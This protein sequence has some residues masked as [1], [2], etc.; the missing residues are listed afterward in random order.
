MRETRVTPERLSHFATGVAVAAGADPSEA[1]LLAQVMVWSDLRGHATQGVYLLPILVKRLGLGLVRSPADMNLE[2]T[3]P[4]AARLDARH[5]FGQ[6]AGRRAMDEAIELARA[7]GIGI[8]TV[9]NSNHYGAAGYYAARAAESGLVGLSASNSMPKVA[10]YGGTRRLMGTNPLGFA[11][12]RADGSPPLV[13]DLATGASAGSRISQARRTGQ[14][15]PEGIALDAEGRPTTDP[16]DVDGG[17]CLLPAGGAKGYCLGLIVEV[18]SGVLTGSAFAPGVGSMFRNL[19]THVR[20]GHTCIAIDIARFL[21]PDEFADRMETL[22]A[23]IKAVPPAEGVDEVMVPGERR[24]RLAD[25]Q[26]Q[27]GILLSE[28][29]VNSLAETAEEAGVKTPW[30]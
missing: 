20:A 3:G 25:E 19:D 15:I 30:E 8:C 29:L 14:P 11:C 27:R 2:R 1:A 9:K 12:P 17:G 28:T 24:A 4:A 7:Q 6:V 5:G 18:L 23:A 10:P 21:P 22:A 16:N 13:I 26:A